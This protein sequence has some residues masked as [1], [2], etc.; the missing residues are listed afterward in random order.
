MC[1]QLHTRWNN[2]QWS[3]YTLNL[4]K[5]KSSK[6]QF[7]HKKIMCTGFWDRKGVSVQWIFYKGETVNAAGLVNYKTWETYGVQL[8][9][10]RKEC[11]V[12]ELCCLMTILGPHTAGDNRWF[13]SFTGSSSFLSKLPFFKQI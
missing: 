6:W 8:K 1:L 2:S 3:G 5:N 10:N 4:P 13:D 11:C 9:P 7:Q 12:K